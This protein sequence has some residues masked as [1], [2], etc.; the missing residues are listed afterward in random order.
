MKV[1][2]KQRNGDGAG[3]KDSAA[4]GLRTSQPGLRS[5]N[6]L[7]SLKTQLLADH[8]ANAQ[9][10]ELR[11]R[12]RWA[13]D[14]SAFL[15]WATPVPLLILPELLT[16]KTREAFRQFRRQQRINASPSAPLGLAA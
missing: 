9:P 3:G 16:E 11:Q 7:E 13:A 4:V 1:E 2:D 14:D 12:L 15:A 8:L 5:M 6:A 10:A